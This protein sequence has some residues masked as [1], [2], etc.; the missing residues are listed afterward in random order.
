MTGAQCLHP[1]PSNHHLITPGW[2][3]LGLKAG[4]R[5]F[6]VPSWLPGEGR[7]CDSI[8][9]PPQDGTPDQRAVAWCL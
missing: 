5:A 8:L 4:S 3:Q 6:L 7:V 9:A 1:V 2:W